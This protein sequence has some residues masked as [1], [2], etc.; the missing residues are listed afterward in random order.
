MA[1]P[2]YDIT[3]FQD[4]IPEKLRKLNLG[5]IESKGKEEPT[6]EPDKPLIDNQAWLY[7]VMAL[8]VL[9]LGFFTLKMIRGEG[10]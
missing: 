2:R 3:R 5:L 9:L 7:G 4:K 1:A 8:V 10:K 6:V